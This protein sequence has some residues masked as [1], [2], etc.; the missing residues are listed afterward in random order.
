M[1]EPQHSTV[2]VVD[3]DEAKR[4]GLVRILSQA[5]FRILEATTGE[6]ALSLLSNNPDLIVLDVKLPGI[7]GYDVCQHVKSDP[8]S[9]NIKILHVSATYTD[10]DHRVEGLMHG[11]DGFLVQPVEPS[12]LVETVKALLR[13]REAE[14][15]ARRTARE[16]RTTFNSLGNGILLLDEGGTVRRCNRSMASI[17]GRPVHEIIGS[18]Y[19]G[20]DAEGLAPVLDNMLDGIQEN[21]GSPS[22]ELVLADRQYLVTVNPVLDER[23]NSTGA[24]CVFTDITERKQMEEELRRRA[25]ALAAADRAKDEFLAT[26]GHELRNPLAVISNVLNMLYLQEGAEGGHD[27]FCPER[28]RKIL[29]RQVST[30]ARLMD[31]LLDVARLTSGKIVLQREPL[32][33]DQCVDSVLED[34]RPQAEAKG[35]DLEYTI[36]DHLMVSADRVRLEQIVTN[37]VANAVRYTDKG[38]IRVSAYRDGEDAAIAVHDTGVGIRSDTLPHVFE[39]FSQGERAGMRA[40]GGLG[41]GLTLVRGLVE[42]HGGTVTAESA[43]EGMGSTFTVRLPTLQGAQLPETPKPV[44]DTTIDCRRVLVVDDN[45]DAAQTLAEILTMWGHTADTVYDGPT[46]V[47]TIRLQRPDVVLLDIG[48]PGLNGYEVVRKLRDAWT[49]PRPILVAVTGYGQ[50]EDRER[51]L[52]AGFDHHLSKPLDLTTL[53]NILRFA[54]HNPPS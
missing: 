5:G 13:L 40:E 17:A 4:Y 23:K 42:Q 53:M 31:D 6:E 1:P 19:R 15:T 33:L 37:L 52:S 45:V 29:D 9:V 20:I 49:E 51:A 22:R 43:G 32:L 11:A 47:K 41:I 39:I 25:E 21:P 27:R 26:L 54:P 10:S 7:S 44:E 28:T 2:L 8:D 36:H 38:S 3:D 46:A 18:S 12:E 50:A 14:E 24:V 35:L 16:W 48:L 30:M 34:L